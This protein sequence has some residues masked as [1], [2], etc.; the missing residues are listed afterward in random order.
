VRRV[1]AH[2]LLQCPHSISDAQANI[3]ETLRALKLS[4]LIKYLLVSFA[5]YDIDSE[6]LFREVFSR[7]P[8]PEF[9]CLRI[10]AM[11]ARIG[12][13]NGGTN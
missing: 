5:G 6:V 7:Y 3:G 10:N 9:K 1:S 11:D 13:A 8:E 12:L 4:N 2:C